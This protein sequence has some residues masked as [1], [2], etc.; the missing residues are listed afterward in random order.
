MNESSARDD[1]GA[2]DRLPWDH[3]AARSWEELKPE[4]RLTF[5]RRSGPG[6][7][8]RNKVETAVV[9]EH[10]PSGVRGQAAERRSQEANRKVAQERLRQALA[11]G[12]RRGPPAP[13]ELALLLDPYRTGHGI[14]VSQSNRDYPAVVAAM[15]DVLESR[16]Y[17]VAD[18]ARYL[19][20]S[21]GQLVRFLK[22]HPEL[23]Q[24]V[25]RA[26]RT[27]RLRPLW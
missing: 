9:I 3:P 23:W 8:H 10:L 7:Q 15:L 18:S 27:R 2:A 11:I 17:E 22:K 19:G 25:N 21:T 14:A 24:E 5:G 26:R 12:V 4:C 1:S 16:G 13:E 6:G 20:L